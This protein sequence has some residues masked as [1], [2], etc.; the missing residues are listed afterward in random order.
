M[1]DTHYVPQHYYILL[2][3]GQDSE[4][5]KQIFLIKDH[6]MH[7]N[8]LMGPILFTSINIQ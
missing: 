3:T 6:M 4:L 8:N 2:R 7:C 1:S 5:D